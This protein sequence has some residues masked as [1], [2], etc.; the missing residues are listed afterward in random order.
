MLIFVGFLYGLAVPLFDV[1][2]A[3]VLAIVMPIFG[4]L[5]NIA[6]YRRAR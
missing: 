4:V 6:F 5:G 1:V 3:I 2:L